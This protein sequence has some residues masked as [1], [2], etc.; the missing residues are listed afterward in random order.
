MPYGNKQ[1]ASV[2]RQSNLTEWKLSKVSVHRIDTMLC[3]LCE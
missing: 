2:L 3:L 1:I